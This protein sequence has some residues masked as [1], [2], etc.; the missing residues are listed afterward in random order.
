VFKII[1]EVIVMED[2]DVKGRSMSVGP[3][4][5]PETE[6]PCGG[7]GRTRECY[8]RCMDDAWDLKGESICS[9]VCGM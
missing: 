9:T 4:E 1:L 5:V 8:G 2:A 3:T 7:E 6:G